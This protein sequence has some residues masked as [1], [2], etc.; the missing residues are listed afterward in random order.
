MGIRPATEAPIHTPKGVITAQMQ[1]KAVEQKQ[2]QKKQQ[3]SGS[4]LT[5]APSAPLTIQP[6]PLQS[7]SEPVDPSS[8]VV[9]LDTPPTSDDEYQILQSIPILLQAHRT[10]LDR[11][12]AFFQQVFTCSSEVVRA[13]F[14]R[15]RFTLPSTPF[16]PFQPIPPHLF[17]P[18]SYAAAASLAGGDGSSMEQY[19][20]LCN[21]YQRR[22]M[23]AGLSVHRSIGAELQY[24]FQLPS[25]PPPPQPTQD[26]AS[27]TSTVPRSLAHHQHAEIHDASM[28]V[29]LT[30][31]NQSSLSSPVAVPP[32]G[33]HLKRQSIE[34]N[35]KHEPDAADADPFTTPASPFFSPDAVL[36]SPVSG[37]SATEERIGPSSS[38]SSS[39]SPDPSSNN[40][41]T[42]DD[43]FAAS[44]SSS[45]LTS[46]A[47][48]GSGD[49]INSRIDESESDPF[50]SGTQYD[51]PSVTF[52]EGSEDDPF[53]SFEAPQPQSSHDQRHDQSQDMDQPNSDVGP[54]TTQI[55]RHSP[56][57]PSDDEDEGEGDAGVGTKQANSRSLQI[58]DGRSH[59]R[60]RSH[61]SSISSSSSAS[62]NPFGEAATEAT[63]LPYKTPFD[64][65]SRAPSDDEVVKAAEEDEVDDDGD[66]AKV[67]RNDDSDE[68]DD[69]GFDHMSSR[70]SSDHEIES[71]DEHAPAS[72]AILGSPSSR[73]KRVKTEADYL[74]ADYKPRVPKPKAKS[75]SKSKR[76]KSKRHGVD[77]TK[78]ADPSTTLPVSSPF[79]SASATDD[80]SNSGNNDSS[81]DDDASTSVA[82]EWVAHEDEPGTHVTAEPDNPFSSDPFTSGLASTLPIAPASSAIIIEESYSSTSNLDDTTPFDDQPIASSTATSTST[83]TIA[84]AGANAFGARNNIAA[85]SALDTPFDD[86]Q[87]AV[88]FSLTDSQTSLPPT[89]SVKQPP[90][91]PFHQPT[92]M[93]LPS[94]SSSSLSLKKPPS[95]S[96]FDEEAVIDNGNPFEDPSANKASVAAA[97]AVFNQQLS[98]DETVPSL[99]S[100][101]LPPSIASVTASSNGMSHGST[102]SSIS[103]AAPSASTSHSQ[104]QLDDDVEIDFSELSFGE[105]IGIGAYAEVFAGS[106]HGC[107]VAIKCLSSSAHQSEEV[108]EEFRKEITILRQLRHPHL[109]L[110]MAACTSK[111]DQLC[112]VTELMSTSLFDLLHNSPDTELSWRARLQIACD[113]AKAMSYLHLHK[114]GAILH[115]DLKSPN[116]LLDSSYRV[117]IADFGLART[118][119]K[120]SSSSSSSSALTAASTT[121]NAN[122]STIV[123]QAGTLQWMAPEVIKGG[124]YQEASDVYSFAIIMW[125]LASR[126]IPWAGLSSSEVSSAV[127]SGQ[128]PAIPNDCPSAYAQLMQACWD[129]DPAK[130]PSFS[131]IVDL[132]NQ[133][134]QQL[135]QSNKRST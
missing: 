2:Q 83:S 55:P 49:V 78:T 3:Q 92:P 82:D 11:Y 88:P 16:Y 62:S 89:S 98:P 108:L 48:S 93:N 106:W 53:A 57:S 6:I 52:A 34:G 114:G 79:D 94:S 103:S 61:H 131:H 128:R 99:P 95:P 71:F 80:S 40:T 15:E 26:N 81:T 84:Q 46:T 60:S 107:D 130:R 75:K 118:K 44:S 13:H 56:F 85:Q 28:R 115:R 32:I 67:S 63:A 35:D 105:R 38:S 129:P 121:E 96:P 87:P 30:S 70:G 134:L 39:S 109:L 12:H 102:S 17:P 19:V 120:M 54:A 29:T 9:P 66:D 36:I 47:P 20:Q 58:N 65:T 112:V 64:A 133:Q 135:K 43:P 77:G 5:S 132:L 21:E 51:V 101:S 18:A 33:T 125:E 122:G 119:S 111:P 123:G 4:H 42:E 113:A 104:S 23:E 27:S 100:T 76:N 24:L 116:L 14:R 50:A 10:L 97:T 124:E 86:D 45:P 31:F 127:L 8:H 73:T 117:K 68:S 90:P 37:S 72:A 69:H 59:S 41:N 126:S 1:A 22:N 7:S 74:P 110:F 25:P 91:S